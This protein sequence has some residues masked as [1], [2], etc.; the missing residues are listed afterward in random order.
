MNVD[1]AYGGC[2]FV[3]PEYRKKVLGLENI[4]SIQINFA[5]LMMLGL[6]GS[7]FFITDKQELAEAM[8]SKMDYDFYRN[9]FTDEHDVWDY[10]DW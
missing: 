1:A 7:L 8:G 10:K 2:A 4:D 9:K 5:K 3:I 6:N